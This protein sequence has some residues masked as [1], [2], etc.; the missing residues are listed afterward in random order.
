MHSTDT[1]GTG[2]GVSLGYGGIVAVGATIS[3]NLSVGG[4]ITYEDTTN[5]DS[6]GIVTA[7][8]GIKVGQPTG[9]GATF[10]PAGDLVV[11]GVA[12]VGTGLSMP[13]SAKAYF[14]TGGD[15]TIYHNGSHSYL[16]N[17]TGNL[18]ITA[19]S[20]EDGIIVRSDAQVELYYNNSKKIETTSSGVEVTGDLNATGITTVAKLDTSG[21]LV[22][23]FTSTTTAWSTTNDWNITNGNLFFT[24]GNLGGTT[25]TI[26]IYST[27]GI[28]TDLSVG[29]AINV[30]GISSVNATTA[31]VN[32]ITIDG[33]ANSVNWVGGTAPAAGGGSG[34]DTYTFNILKVG[35]ATFHVIANQV[36]TSA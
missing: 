23:A 7:R 9:V 2:I 29:Q 28:N 10:N 12:T 17:G 8:N 31:Y 4:T 27:T 34:F 25:N 36:L 33:I 1:A 21:T 13:D 11:A 26:D 18:Y 5:V 19:K 14:G 20:D 32:A 16:T 30:T 22:E 35:N 3:G 6:T 15:L 24:S